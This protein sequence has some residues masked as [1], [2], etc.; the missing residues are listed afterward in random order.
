MM[1]LILG[2]SYISQWDLEARL[3]QESLTTKFARIFLHKGLDIGL[4][5]VIGNKR[6]EWVLHTFGE[7]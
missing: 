2:G 1:S 7:G 5:E 6:E 4:A 3:K